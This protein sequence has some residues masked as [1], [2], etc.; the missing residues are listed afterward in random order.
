[1][2]GIV[3]SD[4]RYGDGEWLGW[5][6]ADCEATIDLKVRRPLSN[7]NLRFY[8]GV[9]QWIWLPRSVEV[10]TSDDGSTYRTAAG[11]NAFDHASTAKVVPV[12]LDVRGSTA[13]YVRVIARRYGA[14]P[15]GSPGAGNEAWLFVDEV[16][17]R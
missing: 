17:V 1:V 7:V 16:V 4:D 8:N 2:N 5:S 14:I 13:R 15:M 12:V 9:G 3:G 10:Q 6:G 11:W